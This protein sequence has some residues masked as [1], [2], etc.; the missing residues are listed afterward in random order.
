MGTSQSHTFL[1]M[2][3]PQEWLQGIREKHKLPA[4]NIGYFPSQNG[5]LNR[6]AEGH[7]M[8][9]EELL[10]SLTDDLSKGITSISARSSREGREILTIRGTH[11]EVEVAEK[12]GDSTGLPVCKLQKVKRLAHPSK[13]MTIQPERVFFE[14]IWD[15]P[16]LDAREI[17]EKYEAIKRE[18]KHAEDELTHPTSDLSDLQLKEDRATAQKQYSALREM[19]SLLRFRSEQDKVTF[20]AQVIPNTDVPSV[21]ED[22]IDSNDRS[23]LLHILSGEAKDKLDVGVPVELALEQNLRPL[24]TSIIAVHSLKEGFYIELDLDSSS[25]AD[26]NIR[27]LTIVSRF[28]MK[29]NEKAV[30]SFLTES[31]HGYWQNLAHL[32]CS[33]SSITPP[34]KSA[35]VSKFYCDEVLGAP[36]LNERQRQA[37]RGA[38]NAPSAF[39]IQGPPGTGKTTV[40]CEI[41]QH[42]VARGERVLMAAPSHVAIDEVLCRIGGRPNVHPIRLSWDDSRVAL[43]ARQYLPSELSRPLFEAISES[44]QEKIRGWQK[45]SDSLGPALALLEELMEASKLADKAS[46]KHISDRRDMEDFDRIYVSA[47]SDIIEKSEVIKSKYEARC[48]DRTL[49]ATNAEAAKEHLEKVW[50]SAG[51]GASLLSYFG[52]GELGRAKR[53]QSACS[54]YLVVLQEQ[55]SA[56]SSDEEALTKKLKAL[57]TTRAAKK[58]AEAMSEADAISRA[59]KRDELKS[60]C[61]TN[62]VL[63]EENLDSNYTNELFCKLSERATRLKIYPN[64]SQTFKD[65]TVAAE[66][67]GQNHDS[68]QRDLVNSANLFFCT[69]TGVSGSP[70]LRDMEFDT[71]II[72]EASRVTDSEFLIGAIRARRWILVGDENQLPP[73]VEQQDE[74]FIHALSALQRSATQEKELAECVSDLGELWHEDEE[75]HKFRNDSVERIA[76]ELRSNGSWDNLYKK[77]YVEVMNSLKTQVKEPERALL[78]AMRDSIVHS[79]FERVVANCP[80]GAKVRLSEQRRMIEPIARIVSGPV[81]GGDYQS[82][83]AEELA[84]SG[85]TPLITTTFST[86]ITFLDTSSLG[87]KGRE[88]QDRNSFINRAEANRIVEACLILDREI[89]EAPEVKISVSILAFYKAQARLIEQELMKHRFNRLIFSVIDA[90]DK[91]QGQESDVVFLS[92]TRTAGTRVSNLFGQWLQ[93]IRRLNVA[94]TRAH[95]ALFLVGQKEML[96][97]LH[98]N[99]QAVAF[100]RN[101]ENLFKQYPEDMKIIHRLGNQ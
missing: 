72:D 90:I 24:K 87:N 50:S 94:C 4:I 65:L 76:S 56:L 12:T 7:Q 99:E 62:S 49:A 34:S 9:E 83:S 25:V 29:A 17:L 47:R 8:S 57:F 73:Y 23:I 70:E 81:Y 86:P 91:I 84:K 11:W 41:V 80:E 28:G 66:N 40:I 2:S 60:A 48:S 10:S 54:R 52:L 97:K 37:V 59:G 14:P 43:N 45:E 31:V 75:L 67:S 100:Y 58:E 5:N 55:I 20:Q 98:S 15:E 53:H 18:Y 96:L 27:D 61:L 64:L 22:K 101:L 1:R 44:S 69:T 82:P 36:K 74:H 26:T 3:I 16:S 71:L 79:L 88:E 39:C 92:F 38:V 13:A 85:V 33:P 68:L 42:L 19:M 35:N 51:F 6:W 89:V 32:L 77:K 30:K 78:N 46:K 21:L 93:D 95:R 63:A